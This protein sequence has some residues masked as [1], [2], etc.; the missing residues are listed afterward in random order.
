MFASNATLGDSFKKIN[1]TSVLDGKTTEKLQSW[2]NF[3][4]DDN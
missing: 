3:I 2:K 4:A 1:F